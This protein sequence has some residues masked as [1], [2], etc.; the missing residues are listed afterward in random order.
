VFGSAVEEL[1]RREDAHL[2]TVVASDFAP[3]LARD[4]GTTEPVRAQPFIECVRSILDRLPR[5]DL[6]PSVG[7]AELPNR[8]PSEDQ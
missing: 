4:L 3:Q 2:A 8:A 1:G 5:H 6:L 7:I